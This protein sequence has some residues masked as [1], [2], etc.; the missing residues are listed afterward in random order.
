MSDEKTISDIDLNAFVDDELDSSRRIEVEALLRGDPLGT[1][2]VQRYRRLDRAVRE[3]YEPISDEPVPPTLMARRRRPRWPIHVAAACVWL[4]IGAGIAWIA[5]GPAPL[6]VVAEPILQ[7][8]LVRPAAFAHAVYSPEVTRPVEVTAREE[9]QLVRW[10]GKRMGVEIKPPDL[11]AQGYVLVGGRLLP[12]TDRMA[13]QFMY[14][15]D[16]GSRVTLYARRGAW[17][18][19]VT[20][21]RYKIEGGAGVFYWIDG[22]FGYALVGEL[23]RQELLRLSESIHRALG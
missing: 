16:D 12:S 3:I 8:H 15:R 17:E 22:P 7:A 14:E 9:D 13:A 2:L 23:S 10:I 20:A 4:A 18:N 21:F 19:E 1:E 6:D 11:T 5:S